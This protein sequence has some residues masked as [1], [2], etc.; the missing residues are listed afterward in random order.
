MKGKPARGMMKRESGQLGGTMAKRVKL[1]TDPNDPYCAEIEKFL[2]GLEIVLE[3]HDI[4]ANPLNVNQLSGLL[5]NFD[6]EHF[7]NLN[8]KT[9]KKKKLDLSPANRQV[10]LEA[11][12][13]D[14]GLLHRPIV[15]SGRLVTFG[16]GR[17]KIL[18][19]LQ[20]K[21]NDVK[22]DYRAESAA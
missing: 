3:V 1:Y 17:K 19:M 4:R 13:Q 18:D 9:G 15:V 11:I 16:Y 12:A 22:S 21:L 14:N 2:K 10:V 8:G 7:L 5:G 20:I 6:I